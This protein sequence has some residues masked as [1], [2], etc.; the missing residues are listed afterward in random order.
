MDQGSPSRLWKISTIAC[1]NRRSRGKTLARNT[2]ILHGA[3]IGGSD[4]R[5]TE[6]EHAF[7]KDVLALVF[8]CC[9]TTGDYLRHMPGSPVA[10]NRVFQK[11]PLIA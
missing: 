5:R 6:A 9:Y 7:T 10:L 11:L 3:H 4:N 1:C 8:R 2:Q